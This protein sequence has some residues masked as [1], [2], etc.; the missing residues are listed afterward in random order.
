VNFIKEVEK[1]IC[2][3]DAKLCHEILEL[4]DHME[5]VALLPLG[6]PEKDGD[7]ERHDKARKPLDEMVGWNG[8]QK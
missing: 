8:Y 6:Y 2:A 7:S 3:F 1:W 4:P 5:V